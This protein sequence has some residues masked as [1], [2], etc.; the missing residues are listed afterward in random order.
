MTARCVTNADHYAYVLLRE[1]PWRL[2]PLRRFKTLGCLDHDA[3]G[4]VVGEL[5]GMIENA[6]F[7]E[8]CSGRLN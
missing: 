7:I 5:A 2:G 8:V 6:L 4:I 1:S 3:R